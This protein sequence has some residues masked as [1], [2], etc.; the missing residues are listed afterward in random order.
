MYRMHSYARIIFVGLAIGTSILLG[1]CQ[2]SGQ[3]AV[4]GKQSAVSPATNTT[5]VFAQI[6][7]YTPGAV[8]A[9]LLSSC[10]LEAAGAAAFGSNPVAL[11][12]GQQ[13]AFKG[14]INASGLTTPSYWLRFDD[15]SANRHLQA[16]VTLT[17]QRPDVASA[18]AGAPLV[19]GFDADLPAGSL[20]N[21]K[22]HV[23]VAAEAGGTIYVCDNGRYITVAY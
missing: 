11:A 23:Y 13:N 22:Y 6:F 17:V 1:A 18:H 20:P 16:P 21:G 12:A 14:W 9:K 3:Q 2:G 19:S 5:A 8:P 4:A 15:Q 7:S 10:N